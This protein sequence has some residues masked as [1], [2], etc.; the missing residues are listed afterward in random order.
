MLPEGISGLGIK[1]PFA[2]I[3]IAFDKAPRPSIAI[4]ATLTFSIMK[5]SSKRYDMT[6]IMPTYKEGR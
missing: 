1:P 5:E 3:T 6:W 4:P 2:A